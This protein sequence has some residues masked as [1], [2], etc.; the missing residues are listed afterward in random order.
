[1]L[2]GFY[3]SSN[4]LSLLFSML[5]WVLWLHVYLQDR[6][7]SKGDP[8]QTRFLGMLYVHASRVM[9]DSYAL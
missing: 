8:C 1:M 5:R 2:K 9:Y 7:V 6:Y 3:G 4:D